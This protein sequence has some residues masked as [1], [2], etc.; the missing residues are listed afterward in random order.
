VNYFEMHVNDYQRKT[1]HLSLVEHGAYFLML[2]ANYASERPLPS[3]KKVL[4]R[5]LRAESKQEKAA[6]DSVVR[7]FWVQTEEGLINRRASEKIVEY[8]EWVEKQ[9]A[10]GKRRGKPNESHGS[11]TG[12]PSLSDGTA[13]GGDSDLDLR[14]PTRRPTH[15]HDSEGAPSGSP[16][17]RAES[18]SGWKPPTEAELTG[19]AFEAKPHA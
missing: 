10:N 4:Y 11:A 19:E 5:L 15:T 12:Q 14:L 8:R 13:K 17:V 2:Q 1:A 9:R 6:I 7:Q 16:R 3:D 18:K